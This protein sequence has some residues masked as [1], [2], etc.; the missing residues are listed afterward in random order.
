LAAAAVWLLLFQSPAQLPDVPVAQAS[1]THAPIAVPTVPTPDPDSVT[2]QPQQMSA[3]AAGQSGGDV[4]SVESPSHEVS[5][6]YVPAS[7][8]ANPN[9]S[10]V[11]VWIGEGEATK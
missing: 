9:A 8:S 7:A 2:P 5:V 1:A 10:T 6:F 11:V 4:E 3:Q